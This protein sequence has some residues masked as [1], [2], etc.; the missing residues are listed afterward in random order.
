MRGNCAVGKWGAVRGDSPR[1]SGLTSR[2]RV[3]YRCA[4]EPR[5]PGRTRGG[6]AWQV[7]GGVRLEPGS[8]LLTSRLQPFGAL[9]M[10]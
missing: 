3:S 5:Q 2:F 6:T 9:L 4:P 10:D 8:Q 1:G 7:G